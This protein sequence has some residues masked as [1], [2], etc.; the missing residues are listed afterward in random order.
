MR[1]AQI[2]VAALMLSYPSISVAQKAEPLR[3]RFP[4]GTTGT[5]VRGA[6]RDR[7]QQEYVL[8]AAK[9]QELRARLHSVP[10]GS[11]SIRLLDATNSE[12]PIRRIDRNR[13]AAALQSDGDYI[14]IVTRVH[15]ARGRS[16]FSLAIQIE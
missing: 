10:A 13:W 8:G 11:L 16:T 4:R 5:T 12:V 1:Y 3:I 7:Q 2:F 14:I 9:G 15:A 6:L